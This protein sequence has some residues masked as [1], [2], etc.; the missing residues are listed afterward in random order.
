MAGEVQHRGHKPDNWVVRGLAAGIRYSHSCGRK[1][2]KFYRTPINVFRAP[3]GFIIALTYSSKSEWVKDVLAA[4]GCKL[5]TRG[6]RYR[7]AAPKVVHDSSR[8]RFPIPVRLILKL[9]GADEYMELSTS[10][11]FTN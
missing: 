8:R 10:E 11:L 9:V 2:G 3:D 5:K 6:K 4:G 7:L 1:S